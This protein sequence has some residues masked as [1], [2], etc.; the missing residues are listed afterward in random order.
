MVTMKMLHTTWSDEQRKTLT[1][2]LDHMQAWRFHAAHE[3]F[4]SAWRT[5]RIPQKTWLHGLAQIAASYHQ[6]SLGRGVAAVRTWR[7]ARAKLEALPLCPFS[8]QTEALHR[9]LGLSLDGPR[10]F[11]PLRLCDHSLP[12]LAL[13]MLQTPTA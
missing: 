11:D 10:F 12:T 1:K 3:E 7:K 5:A 13:E 9:S 8:T 4:E 2:A 6:L